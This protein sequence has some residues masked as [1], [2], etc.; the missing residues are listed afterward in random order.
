VAPAAQSPSDGV[1]RLRTLASRQVDAQQA[2]EAEIVRLLATGHSWTDIGA[3][4]G[5]SRQGARQRYRRLLDG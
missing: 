1:E 4:V 2:V 5:L 3:G